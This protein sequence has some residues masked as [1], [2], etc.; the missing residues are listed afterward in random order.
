MLRNLALVFVTSLAGHVP[1]VAEQQLILEDNPILPVPEQLQLDDRKVALGEKLFH[2]P[3]LSSSGTMACSSCHFMNRSGDDE[4]TTSITNTGEPD[5]F[6]TPTIFNI[7]LSHHITWQGKYTRL[8][9]QIDASL[10][11]PKHMAADWEE[12]LGFLQNEPEYARLFREIYQSI[13]SRDNVLD[14]IAEYERSL[15]TPNAPFDRWL[16]GDST[17]IDQQAK[18][19]YVLFREIGCIACHQGVN[20]GSN[21]FAPHGIFGDSHAEHHHQSS[22]EDLSRYSITGRERD[23]R[24]FRVPSLRNVAETGPWFHDGSAKQLSEAVLEMA[25]HQLGI[26]LLDDDT[27]KIVRFLESL[28]GIYRGKPVGDPK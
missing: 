24:V 26:K 1:A 16:K 7:G 19:G 14:S 17:A 23:K 22:M 20:V 25:E 15:I 4:R 13:S 6:N 18:E 21:L 11:N 2:E 9:P 10:T 27:N 12:L 8:E 28:T 5:A 3:R